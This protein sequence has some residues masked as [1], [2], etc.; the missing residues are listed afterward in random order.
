MLYA[1][2]DISPVFRVM[3]YKMIGNTVSDQNA[4][5]KLWEDLVGM[6]LYKIVNGKP[7]FS[8]VY[9]SAQ[10]GADFIFKTPGNSVVIEVG[11]G[12]KDFRQVKKTLDKV[13]TGYGTIIS[14]KG[15]KL[16]YREYINAVKVP[17]KF[18]ILL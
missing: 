7:E 8:L 5:G 15:D 13:G 4:R 9:D 14:E 12:N 16:E 11:V 2:A 6:Y 17:K 18:F 10:G 1:V 3:Y